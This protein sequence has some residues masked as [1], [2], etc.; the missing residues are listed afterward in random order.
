MGGGLAAPH[1]GAL[2]VVLIALVAPTWV[3]LLWP[4]TGA[5]ER[6]VGTMSVTVSAV[7]AAKTLCWRRWMVV[8]IAAM[9]FGLIPTGAPAAVGGG[10][11]VVAFGCFAATCVAPPGKS[12]WQRAKDRLRLHHL[13]PAGNPA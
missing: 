8:A 11:A 3:A 2:D 7:K 13:Q 1:L 4:V 10:W 6:G 5:I 12:L 9:D